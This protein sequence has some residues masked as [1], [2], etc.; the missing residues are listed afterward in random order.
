[1][2]TLGR[3][4]YPPFRFIEE[5]AGVVESY[6]SW[7]WVIGSFIHPMKALNKDVPQDARA[8]LVADTLVGLESFLGQSSITAL[9]PRATEKAKALHSIL[10]DNYRGIVDG[11]S[12]LGDDTIKQTVYGFTVSLQDELDRMITLTVMP[13]GSLDIRALVRSLSKRYP[14]R[15]QELL[16]NFIT[17]E[18]DHAGKCLAYELPTSC[19]FHILRAVETGMKGYVHAA[20][21]T[22]PPMKNRNWGEYIEQLTKAGAHSDLIDVLRVLKTKRN[23]LMHP[24]DNLDIDEAIT[25]LCICQSAI[26]ALVEDVRRR[27]LDIKFKESLEKMPTL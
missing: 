2:F 10:S 6:P 25:L 24:T 4:L 1:M 21:G 11:S 16:D 7:F 5:D 3:P 20:T 12:P 26:D 14:K 27:S 17:S 15:T 9:L 19:G 22:L 18:I 13:K 8:K 23:P